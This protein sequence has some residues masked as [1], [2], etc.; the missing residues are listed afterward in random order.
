[1]HEIIQQRRCLTRRLV[2]VAEVGEIVHVKQNVGILERRQGLRL[3]EIKHNVL[4][5][6]ICISSCREQAKAGV[7][8]PEP[9]SGVTVIDVCEDAETDPSFHTLS[10]SGSHTTVSCCAYTA[11]RGSVAHEARR[12][13]RNACLCVDDGVR[14]DQ[15]NARTASMLLFHCNGWPRA[16]LLLAC[17][18]ACLPT[19][20]MRR[21]RNRSIFHMPL[22]HC[23]CHGELS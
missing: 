22:V 18:H 13:W 4:P 5:Q 3:A 1:M 21:H 14:H 9:S 20:L 19:I 10:G 8:T 23:T 7:N 6:K 16:G 17:V 12:V 2:E 15:S 11:Q